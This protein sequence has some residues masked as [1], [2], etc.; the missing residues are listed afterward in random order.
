MNC[1]C[2]MI[3]QTK[4]TIV[5]KIFDIKPINNKTVLK[6]KIKS[7][8][9]EATY[10]HDKEMPNVG[11]N[12]SCLVVILIDFVLKIDEICYQQALLK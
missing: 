5:F 11:S 10:F 12:Y 6:T 7:S 9:D 2:I 1:T 4:L 8:T 3:F